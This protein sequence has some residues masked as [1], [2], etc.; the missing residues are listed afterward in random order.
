[1]KM[2]YCFFGVLKR[3]KNGLKW[4]KMA[5]KARWNFIIYEWGRG[6]GVDWIDL[7]LIVRFCEIL[8]H[9]PNISRL[10]ISWDITSEPQY[11]YVSFFLFVFLSSKLYIIVNVFCFP[12]VSW[13][14]PFIFASLVQLSIIFLDT[15]SQ[16]FKVMIIIW[17]SVPWLD[18]TISKVSVETCFNKWI[19]M[20]VNRK[21]KDIWLPGM[22][23][24]W[25][26]SGQAGP[27]DP[28]HLPL[29][30]PLHPHH[31]SHT[32]HLHPPH[33]ARS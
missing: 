27:W 24:G 29:L 26:G 20:F 2:P 7:S 3:V 19:S 23:E 21:F 9:N 13:L 28:L 16:W 25:D 30:P 6:D 12:S 18:Y 22:H 11:V 32:L 17:E 14:P 5:K 15:K 10:H 33:Q 31:I 4:L 8:N 1:M